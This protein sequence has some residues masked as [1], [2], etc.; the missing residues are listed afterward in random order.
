MLVKLTLLAKF[1]F[2]AAYINIVTLFLRGGVPSA[3]SHSID[4]TYSTK[5]KG[6]QF[7]KYYLS[8]WVILPHLQQKIHACCSPNCAQTESTSAQ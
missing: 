4:G 5:E 1:A 7:A 2:Q 8:F 6:C 3:N